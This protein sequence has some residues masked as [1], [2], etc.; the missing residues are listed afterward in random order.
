MKK[1]VSSGFIVIS[2]SGK[3]LLGK[4]NN[5]KPPYQ[6]TIFKGGQEEGETLIDTAIRELK[7]ETGIDIAGDDRLNKHISTN[8]VFRYSMRTKN[9]YLYILKDVEG[10][11]DDF[12]FVCDSYWGETN[13]PEISGYKWV[14]MDDVCNWLF[15]SQRGLVEFL[16]TYGKKK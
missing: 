12:D 2:K 13:Q 9:V 11:L 1:I 10:V 7:E 15:P 8:Y 3:V 14:E 6:W 4:V 16:K 5:Q